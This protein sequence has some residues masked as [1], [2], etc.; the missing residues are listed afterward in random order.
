MRKRVDLNALNARHEA[1]ISERSTAFPEP[2]AIR[3]EFCENPEELIGY[4]IP[5]LI[6]LD[7]QRSFTVEGPQFGKLVCLYSPGHAAARTL[8]SNFKHQLGDDARAILL[9]TYHALMLLDMKIKQNIQDAMEGLIREALYEATRDLN[10][11]AFTTNIQDKQW[12]ESIKKWHAAASGKRIASR[13]GPQKDAAKFLKN[14]MEAARKIKGEVTQEKLVEKMKTSTRAKK[15]KM[16]GI[17]VRGLQ[18]QMESYN[19]SWDAV[20]D[21]C[22]YSRK[23]EE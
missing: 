4:E 20:K 2:L 23:K 12:K 13:K 1:E 15:E 7:T 17:S 22:E 9:S 11:H 18:K 10:G 3:L 19:Y 8:A 6:G 16:E 14:I 5:E 21:I